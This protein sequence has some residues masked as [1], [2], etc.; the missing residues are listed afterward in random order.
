MIRCL[1]LFF[2]VLIAGCSTHPI[3]DLCDTIK[4]GRMGPNK[5]PPY[6]GVAI[7][8]GPI[9]PVMGPVIGPPVPPPFPGGGVVPPP[10][11]LPGNRGPIE[12]SPP[13]P[14]GPF[15]PL[16]PDPPREIGR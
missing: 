15:P 11:P 14:G 6:G 1:T 3:T 8:Q 2:C 5:V 4:P 16:P 7:P 13:M 12:L 9:V 10:A